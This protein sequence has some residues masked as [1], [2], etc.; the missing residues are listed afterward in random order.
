MTTQYTAG[1]YLLHDLLRAYATERA[2]TD[3]SDTDRRA[4]LHRVFEHYL[5]TAHRADMVLRPQWE[6]VAPVQPPAGVT[7]EHPTDIGQALAWLTSEEAILLAA[8][9]QAS[10][11][12]AGLDGYAWRLAA[13]I[14]EFLDRRGRWRDI[15][16]TQGAALAAAGRL[17]D[18]CGQALAHTGLG[19]AHAR[20]GHDDPAMAHLRRALELYRDLGD[21]DQQAHTHVHL[22]FVLRQRPAD[23]PASLSHCRQ[24]LE[25]FRRTGNKR[26]VG[27][28]LNNLGW[29]HA[30]QGDHRAAL[31][32]CEQAVTLQQ[33]IGD[34]I[35]T[36]FTYD[37]LGYAH[38]HLGHH[39]QACTSYRRAISL[40][41]EAS[42][43][44]FEAATLVR[45]GDSHQ[46]LGDA[47]AAREAWQQALHIFDELGH[48]DAATVRARLQ[49]GH[50][51]PAS[52]ER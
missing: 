3:D 42:N 50:A 2:N 4:A 19:R 33:E 27:K 46:A 32:Y 24:A 31:A 36:A 20:L 25:L 13:A 17:D 49:A 47:G 8:I 41:R 10:D 15:L 51:G 11:G 1:R 12:H 18:R 44:P 22:G 48:S 16:W 37:S 26:G 39:R 38:H 7:P 34:R 35:G 23:R 6:P 28:I 29:L 21:L 40:Y 43:R 9:R 52:E 45:L 14:E 5:C 30:L